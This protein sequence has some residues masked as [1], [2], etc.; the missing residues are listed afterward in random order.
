[1]GGG[2]RFDCYVARTTPEP[3]RGGGSGSVRR[4][5]P[6]DAP[7][8]AGLPSDLESCWRFEV[9]SLFSGRPVL[10]CPPPPRSWCSSVTLPIRF[11]AP[12][13]SWN[14]SPGLLFFASLFLSPADEG[15]DPVKEKAGESPSSR[16]SLNGSSS[17]LSPFYDFQESKSSVE[18]R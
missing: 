1:M 7:V 3:V 6:A 10:P 2:R 11:K 14:P 15:L 13:F 5:A 17:S 12:E 4:C 18:C 9:F 16:V 8:V